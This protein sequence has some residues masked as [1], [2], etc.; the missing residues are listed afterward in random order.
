MK[1]I[2]CICL[3]ILFYSFTSG[4]GSKNEPQKAAAA[5]YDK[6]LDTLSFVMLKFQSAS[7]R[8]K[9]RDSLIK[10]FFQSRNAYKKAEFFIDIFD[11]FIAR[12]LNGPDLLKIDSDAPTDSM[13][14]H[15]LQTIEAILYAS[16]IDAGRLNAEIGLFIQNINQLRNDPDRIYYFRDDKIWEAMRLGVFRIISL[17]ITGFDAP[18]SFH[19][20]PET[21]A[22]LSCMFRTIQLY[23]KNITAAEY[24]EARRLFDLADSY[25]D[26]HNNFNTF[27]RLSFIRNHINRISAWITT[28][29]KKL[30]YI[31]YN[32]LTPL[33]PDAP[34][35]FAS[36]IMNVSFFSPNELYQLTPQRIALGKRLFY[37]T[38]MSGNGSR[39]CASCHQPQKAF[40]DGLQ[41][42]KDLSGNKLLLRNTPTLWNAVFQ[43]NQFYDSRAMTLEIQ[44]STVVHDPDEMNG[45]LAD[46][47]PKLLA[48]KEYY[49]LFREAYPE[50]NECIN[51]YTIAN[52]ISSFMRSLVSLNSRFD[53]YMRRQ[54]DSLTANEKNGFNLFMGKAKCGTCHYA[55][56][57]NGLIPPQYQETESE[58][59][60]VP[61]DEKP[62]STLDEDPGRFAFT[63]LPFH[64]HSF[65]TS[66][67]RNAALTAP[68]MHNGVFKTLEAVID[69]YND[70]GGAGRGIILETQ[71]LPTDKLNL[72]KKEKKDIIA[73]L[74]TLTDTTS[75]SFSTTHPQIPH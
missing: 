71:T 41:K 56:V 3:L 35:L 19:S 67:V 5:Y 11:P 61:A 73:F 52:A 14:P 6:C 46:Q 42:P 22:V 39:S 23:K 50:S 59:L 12:K 63:K 38:R 31:N 40:T 72:T 54:T 58:T 65:K 16:D 8:T 28:C 51:E 64:K 68:Y 1:I 70:G 21:R 25:L 13:K 10:H 30:G 15:G 49:A 37:D 45:S 33:N 9:N 17:G 48:D 60:A 4:T 57:F 69:F 27:D 7:R 34:H 2:G 47:V 53:R 55:P 36:G 18:L 43:K 20:L 74:H 44:L 66:T 75:T 24:N 26:Q 29:S 32:Q 62:T